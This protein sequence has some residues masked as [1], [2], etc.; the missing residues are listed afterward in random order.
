MESIDEKTED[1]F[2]ATSLLVI[3][4]HRINICNYIILE[5]N[6]PISGKKVGQV[7]FKSHKEKKDILFL[8]K[9]KSGGIIITKTLILNRATWIFTF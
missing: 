2:M 5:S 1:T 3:L 8:Q 6:I 4:M 9:G 7:I